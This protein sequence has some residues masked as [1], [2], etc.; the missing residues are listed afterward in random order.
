MSQPLLA[1]KKV[2][3]VVTVLKFKVLQEGHEQN[4]CDQDLQ[5]ALSSILCPKA[6]NTNG[7]A[8]SQ[9]KTECAESQS[10]KMATATIV[11]ITMALGTCIAIRRRRTMGKSLRAT[12][13]AQKRLLSK[14]HT[15]CLL[16]S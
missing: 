5:A 1:S 2:Q 3:H 10:G 8:K 12:I 4:A 9:F 13:L 6:G 16:G 11:S 14:L 7:G 15:D